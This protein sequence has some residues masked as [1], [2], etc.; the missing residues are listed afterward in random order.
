MDQSK[1]QAIALMRYSAISPLVAGTAGDYESESAYF[2]E[3][4][5]RG[6]RAPDG[7]VRNYAPC[8]I[9]KWYS[10]YKKGGFDSLVP[11][12]R[13]AQNSFRSPPSSGSST[14]WS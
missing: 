7:S 1:K 12:K 14:R 11:K 13:S 6:I 4:S 3:T 5:A 10:L 2:R 9:Q 8:T